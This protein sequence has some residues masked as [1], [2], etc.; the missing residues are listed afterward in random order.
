M[1]IALSN[2]FRLAAAA[3]PAFPGPIHTAAAAVPPAAAASAPAL[4]N[5]LV[6][7]Q[8]R[9]SYVSPLA[10]AHPWLSHTIAGLFVV[11][12]VALVILLALQT[13][14][15][16]GLSGTIGGRVESSYRPRLGAD[17]Q[18]ARTT[19][20]IAIAFAFFAL[21]LSLTGI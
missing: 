15:Q 4:A 20:Y 19:S 18:M 5:D 14:K 16:E 2:L 8:F 1:T 17:Q 21:L 6:N 9:S 10:L 11:C 7:Y 13:T 12:A 3:P